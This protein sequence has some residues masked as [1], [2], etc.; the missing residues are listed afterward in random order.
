MLLAAACGDDSG[1]TGD[2]ASSD[3]AVAAIDLGVA[4]L[5]A[6]G[7]LAAADL[8]ANGDLARS[9]DLATADLSSAPD[10]VSAPDLTSPP[11]LTFSCGTLAADPS[12]VY[13]DKSATTASVGTQ[14]CPFHTVREATT[15]AAPGAATTRTIHLAGGAY[16]ESGL[17]SVGAR[18]ILAGAGEALVAISGGGTCATAAATCTVSVQAG[19]TLSGVT[20][21]SSVGYAVEIGSGAD[22]AVIDHVTARDSAFDGFCVRASATLSNISALS[23]LRWGLTGRS[24]SAS[25]ITLSITN[26]TI[27]GNQQGGL[28]VDRLASLTLTGGTVESNA[29]DGI[30]LGDSSTV[31]GAR[32]FTLA[33]LSVRSNLG[34]GISVASTGSLH[35]RGSTLLGNE[36]G[37]VFGVGTTNVL[38]V[39]TVADAGGNTFGVATAS[40]RNVRSGLCFEQSGATSSRVAEGDTWS[41]CPPTSS[42]SPTSTCHG[43]NTYADV[44]YVPAGTGGNPVAAPASCTIGP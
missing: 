20:A 17:V 34:Y 7:D 25:A 8:A 32:Q 2:L 24:M 16:V 13:V 42:K 23:N 14:A 15:L 26:V 12:D 5:A 19:G 40:N 3:F 37:L 41:A 36:A 9:G 22:G 38:D 21:S 1:G 30:D 39:G 18:V 31:T 10:L 28:L 33:N 4:D 6:N 35:L 44:G 27:R 29:L 11:D 43:I